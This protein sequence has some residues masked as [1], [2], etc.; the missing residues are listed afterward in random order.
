MAMRIVFYAIAIATSF[1]VIGF[2]IGPMP[3]AEVEVFE[4]T[5]GGVGNMIIGSSK[6]TVIHSNIENSFGAEPKPIECPR[7]WTKASDMNDTYTKCLL[8]SDIWRAGYISPNSCSSGTDQHV[9]LYF[10]N[11]HLFKV[12]VRCTKAI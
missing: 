3:G 4:I 2:I 9:T 5:S 1:Y 11:N 10:V 8:N 12:K 6:E 7:N